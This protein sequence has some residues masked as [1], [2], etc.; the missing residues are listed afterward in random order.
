MAII[1]IVVV[2]SVLPCIRTRVPP[3]KKGG[4]LFDLSLF[5]DRGFTTMYLMVSATDCFQEKI[6]SCCR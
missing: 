1:F 4:P 6:E 3:I 5:K 2:F